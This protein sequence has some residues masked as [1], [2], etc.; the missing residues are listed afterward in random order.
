ML[1][2][3][4][5]VVVAELGWMAMSVVDTIMVGRLGA[6]AIGAVSIGTVVFYVVGVFGTGLL[7][8]LDTLVPRAFGSR[9]MASCHRALISAWW[10][11]AFLGPAL[12]LP[13]FALVALLPRLGLAPGVE[14]LA[15]PYT[16]ALV[17]STVPL[18]LFMTVRQYLQ[19]MNIVR[20]VMFTLISANLVNI[21]ANWTLIFGNFGSPAFGVTGAGWASC[22]SRAYM[23]VALT[24]YMLWDARRRKTGLFK[25]SKRPDGATLRQLSAMG[26]PA[27]LQRLIEISVFALA[28]TLVARLDAVSLAAHQIALQAASVTFMVPLGVSSAAAV[29][30]G[31]A[32]GRRDAAGAGRAGW[33][34]LL[35]GVAFMSLAG[36]A[37]LAF[38]GVILRFFT[39][40]PTVIAIGG[41]LFVWAAVFQLFDGA[42]VV[43]TGALRGAGDTRTPMLVNLVGH[44]ALGLPI[45]WYLCFER[46]M[47]A[48][49]IWAGLSIGLI[50]VGAVLLF[51]W[52]RRL[53]YWRNLLA[54]SR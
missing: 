40:E 32:L 5:P 14:A 9:D 26:F 21:A 49:G 30:V 36:I 23:C 38:P 11:V 51:A 10:G 22:V 2:L 39:V 33:T 42:Q 43:A 47:G 45:G 20:P 35:L 29:R 13:S 37:F 12:M 54:E 7:L 28:T 24:G 16:S 15:G 1:R 44:W 34:A 50:A 52:P 4:T 19:G 27:A 18:L 48:A 31:Q 41:A 3:A 8:G 25:A 17:W 6:E 53:A 46:E